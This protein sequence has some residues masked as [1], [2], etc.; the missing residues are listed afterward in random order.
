MIQRAFLMA[1][2]CTFMAP[3]LAQAE[4]FSDRTLRGPYAYGIDG[5]VGDTP[6]ASIGRT[7]FDGKGGCSSIIF[8]NFGGT[9]LFLKT[10]EPDDC[11]YTVYPDGTGLLE[12]NFRAS[13]SDPGNTFI[14]NFVIVNQKKLF[15]VSTDSAN[16]TVALGVLEKQRGG[17]HHDDDD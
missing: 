5:V 16:Q 2:L 17:G 9:I 4:N 13:A 15:F 12:V 14:V 11:F 7:V 1:L 10:I 6:G 8:F 3:G